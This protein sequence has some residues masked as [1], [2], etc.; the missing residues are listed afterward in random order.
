MG[1]RM[2]IVSSAL[3]PRRL[4]QLGQVRSSHQPHGDVEQ[5]VLLSTVVDG[6]D[7]GVLECSQVLALATEAFAEDIVGRRA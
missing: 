5:A 7:V 3:S 2:S 1:S 6:H 4:N